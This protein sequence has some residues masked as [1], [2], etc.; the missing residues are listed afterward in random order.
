MLDQEK[1]D[2]L[3]TCYIK[4]RDLQL[5]LKKLRTKKIYSFKIRQNF[6]I[7][8]K[9]YFRTVRKEFSIL[10]INTDGLDRQM[11]ELLQFSNE[12]SFRYSYLIL[13]NKISKS[14]GK[15]EIEREYYFSNKGEKNKEGFIFLD[16]EKK[17][18][19]TLLKL[20]P[21]V[22]ISYKQVLLDLSNKE[23]ISFKGTAGE[24]R[25]ILRQVLDHLAPDEVVMKSFG[26]KL[27]ND[28]KKPTMKQKT[29]FILKSRGQP[30]N[31]TKLAENTASIIEI[32]EENISAFLRSLYKSGSILTHTNA[33]LARKKVKQLK[34]YL[35]SILCELLEV[36]F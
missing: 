20:L 36:I 33:G 2:A 4:I 29:R 22:A 1:N 18:Y 35:D 11:Q 7:L 12:V 3:D 13:L 24:I 6:K 27:E 5:F 8:V 25:E 16:I 23:R 26:F 14:I 28:Y 19:Q 9:Y 15:L 32:G 17:I 21:L 31:Q 30:K 10:K 34:I